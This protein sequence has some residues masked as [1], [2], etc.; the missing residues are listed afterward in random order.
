MA[1]QMA[2]GTLETAWLSG[3]AP[4]RSQTCRATGR[5]DYRG[6]VERRIALIE[7]DANIGLIERP[8]YKR[9]WST[10]SW[11]NWSGTPCEPGC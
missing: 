2:A 3:T 8:E 10:K 6:I 9:R 4:R 7:T 11:E 1:R 5:T